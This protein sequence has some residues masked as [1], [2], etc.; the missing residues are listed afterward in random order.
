MLHQE[1]YVLAAERNE[2]SGPPFLSLLPVTPFSD[3]VFRFF[4]TS[5]ITF[6]SKYQCRPCPADRRCKFALSSFLRTESNL[7]LQQQ[8][9]LLVL[10]GQRQQMIPRA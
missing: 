2:N 7:V 8:I 1:P 9:L 6:L 3:F 5:F 4:K 10:V